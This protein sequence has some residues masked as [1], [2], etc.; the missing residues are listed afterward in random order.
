MKRVLFTLTVLTAT[1][2]GSFAQTGASISTPA[3]TGGKFSIGV[4]AGLPLGD[5]S[6]S[7][8]SIIG[9]SVKYEA[10]IGVNTYFTISGG[11][12]SYT[13][14]NVLIAIG[15]PSSFGFVPLKAGIKYYSTDGF[16]LEGQVGVTISTE[17]NG[18]NF[19]AYSPGVG[20]SFNGGLEAGVRFEGWTKGTGSVNQLGLRL[21]YRF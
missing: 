11:Y 19:F 13:T 2:L 4:E 14:K 9:G 12:N 6:D 1:T 7:F 16:F 18:S 5:A 17:K 8:S 15:V 20:Y 21:A 10:S 3:K